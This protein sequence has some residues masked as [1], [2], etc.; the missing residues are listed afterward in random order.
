MD[1]QRFN[2]ALERL[3]RVNEVVEK[4]DAA[5]RAATFNL[6]APYIAEREGQPPCWGRSTVQTTLRHSR[7][8][9]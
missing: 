9:F 3:N 7:S 1:E 8:S 4:L 2:D 6:L 5:I